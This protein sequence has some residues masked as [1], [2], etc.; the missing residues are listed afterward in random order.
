M[1]SLASELGVYGGT[2]VVCFV[3]GLVP[4]INAELWLIGLTVSLASA[5]PLPAVVVLAALGQI[6]AKSVLFGGGR[7]AAALPGGRYQAK[8][9]R[10]RARLAGWRRKP[11]AVLAVSASVGLPPFYVMAPLAGALGIRFRPFLVIGFAGRAIRFAVVVILARTGSSL[12]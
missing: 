1:E 8:L 12:V 7:G 6:L 3:G 5:A 2:F 9:D 10:A 11:L 4:I